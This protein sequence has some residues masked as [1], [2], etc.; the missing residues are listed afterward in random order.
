MYVIFA[1]CIGLL[2]LLLLFFF[3]ITGYYYVYKKVNK[4]ENTRFNIF[5]KKFLSWFNFLTLR[6][7]FSIFIASILLLIAIGSEG[8]SIGTTLVSTMSIF[9][10][11]LNLI[12]IF[13][14]V[15]TKVFIFARS[16]LTNSSASQS[17]LSKTEIEAND[18]TQINLNIRSFIP[19]GYY[20]KFSEK[21]P[22]KLGGEIRAIATTSNKGMINFSCTIPYSRRGVYEIGPTTFFFQDIFGLTKIR[23][24]NN[25]LFKLT[26][27]PEI[28]KIKNFSFLLSPV[29][30]YDNNTIQTLVNTEDFY[31]VRPYQR[32]DDIRKMHW[33]LTA[34]QDEFMIRIPETTTINFRS[35]NIFIL[36]FKPN[37]SV[38]QNIDR[39]Y[40]TNLNRYE[41][42]G[43]LTLDRQIMIATALIDFALRYNIPITVYYYKNKKIQSF[44]PNRS[45]P[46]EWKTICASIDLQTVAKFDSAEIVKNLNEEASAI[47]ITSELIKHK[48]AKLINQLQDKKIN[49]EIMYCP[50]SHYVNL[51]KYK[52]NRSFGAFISKVLFTKP[53]FKQTTIFEKIEQAI[54][55][56]NKEYT[57]TDYKFLTDQ[58]KI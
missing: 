30:G 39:N 1:C 12:F 35:I 11:I 32:G 15:I 24:I 31:G 20:V 23:F 50:L 4:S 45:T 29:A 48:I 26:I 55:K 58:E 49:T 16:S 2:I 25:S 28:P 27:L 42:L 13:I 51:N 6:G 33:K 47:I 9:I 8:N 5:I 38:I 19:P 37:I 56:Q 46:K 22:E 17:Y 18:S 57:E 53:Y 44:V 21:L 10:L 34:K 54:N 40:S 41:L 3:V 7:C 14:A 36:N 43:E 52:T